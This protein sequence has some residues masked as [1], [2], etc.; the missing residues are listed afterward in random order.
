MDKKR[1]L[2]ELPM[3]LYEDVVKEATRE[4]RSIRSTI[5]ILVKRGLERRQQND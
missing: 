5:N 3:D 1:V 2:I 4:Q